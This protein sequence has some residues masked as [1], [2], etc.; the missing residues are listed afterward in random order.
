MNELQQEYQAVLSYL[1][2]MQKI[3]R[4]PKQARTSLNECAKRMKQLLEQ[5]KEYQQERKITITALQYANLERYEKNLLDEAKKIEEEEIRQ[6]ELKK[7][8]KMLNGEK[9]SLRFE[10]E[11]LQKRRHAYHICSVIVSVFIV[12][13]L[14]CFFFMARN[15]IE[16]A[17]VVFCIL[18]I[19]ILGSAAYLIYEVKENEKELKLNE[20]KKQKAVHLSNHAKVKLVN[21]VNY[22]EYMYAKYM[23]SDSKSLFQLIQQYQKAKL[24]EQEYQQNA[25]QFQVCSAQ[26]TKKLEEI[27][28][29]DVSPWV[30]QVS[31]LLEQKEWDQTKQRLE[32]R[33]QRLK[34]KSEEQIEK[35]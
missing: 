31:I 32:E 20:K 11:L 23:V 29:A 28:L 35:D 2:D 14:G 25:A 9:E 34:Q 30:Y 18:A 27:G 12:V 19:L 4:M 1:S 7:D 22:V 3:E 13:I 6:K 21:N 10:A 17:L 5:R 15:R 16:N 8:M 26:L 33:R 24:L